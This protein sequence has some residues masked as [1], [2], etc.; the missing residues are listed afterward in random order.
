MLKQSKNDNDWDKY[1]SRLQKEY[2]K[3]IETLNEV[4]S[5]W[6]FLTAEN[7]KLLKNYKLLDF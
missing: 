1:L 4:H 6:E 5:L 7:T 3:E 2:A